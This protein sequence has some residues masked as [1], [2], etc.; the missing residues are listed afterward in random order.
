MG[1]ALKGEHQLQRKSLLQVRKSVEQARKFRDELG[2]RH[3]TYQTNTL[4]NRLRKGIEDIDGL[5]KPL[6]K[7]FVTGLRLIRLLALLLKYGKN[8]A[9][10]LAGLEL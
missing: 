2:S 7:P 10:R 4:S 6:G 5:V 9:R 1:N 3:K 8:R